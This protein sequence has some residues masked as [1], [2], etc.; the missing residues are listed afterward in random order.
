MKIYYSLFLFFIS[1]FS[2][3]QTT[4]TINA[5]MYYYTPS[6][7]T[8]SQGDVVVWVND[9]GCHD[10]NGLSNS[11]TGEP[12]NNPEDFSSE[13]TCESGVE[14]YTHTF[15]TIGDYSYD[16]S[17]YGHASSGMVGT[18]IVNESGCIDDDESA[19]MLASQFN[20]SFSGGCEEAVDYFIAS[21]YPCETDLS[22]LG[23]SGT[24]YDLCEC[25]C[26]EEVACEDDD[27]QIE[28]WFGSFFITN[29]GSLINYLGANYG[30]TLNE[31]CDW[32]GAPML[33]LGGAI[34]SDFCACSCDSNNASIYENTT[35]IEPVIFIDIT[36]RELNSKIYNQ[37][38]FVI[39]NDGSVQKLIIQQ[40]F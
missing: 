18:I 3:S 35:K 15:N 24:I 21:G 13:I 30:Y 6:N 37:P 38:M 19:E 1:V 7:L 23:M 5:G 17:Y 34:I 2:I 33:D 27:A 40:K 20:P 14:I 16:C 4:H 25:S 28:E 11:I 26:E 32:N 31:S 9:G 12:F 22:V 36:G 8:I 39:Y 10:V 29:C